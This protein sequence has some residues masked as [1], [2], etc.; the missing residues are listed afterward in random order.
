MVLKKKKKLKLPNLPKHQETSRNVIDFFVGKNQ[1]PFL[2]SE[3]VPDSWDGDQEPKMVPTCSQQP[4]LSYANQ[5]GSI[6]SSSSDIL[7]HVTCMTFW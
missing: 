7:M 1:K 4:Y 5:L 3:D 2:T 6:P